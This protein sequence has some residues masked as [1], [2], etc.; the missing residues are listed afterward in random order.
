MAATIPTNPNTTFQQV[1]RNAVSQLTSLWS[2][3]LTQTQRDQWQVYADNVPL[4]KR[5]GEQHTVTSWSFGIDGRKRPAAAVISGPDG[6][7]KARSRALWIELR[8]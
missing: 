3:V 1:V 6:K 2:D 7:V 8:S 4:T 5:H